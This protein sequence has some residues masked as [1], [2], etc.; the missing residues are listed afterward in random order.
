MHKRRIYRGLRTGGLCCHVPARLEALGLDYA[1]SV[2]RLAPLHSGFRQTFPRESALAFGSWLSLL[3]MSPSRYSHRG[4]APHKFA[5]MLGAHPS[6]ERT[7]SGSRSIPTLGV[8]NSNL[9]DASAMPTKVRELLAQ[10]QADGWRLVRQKGSHRQYH[11][12]SKPG[13]VTVAGQ[14]SVEV[15]PGT[16]SS[17]L[18]Q[19]GL[20]K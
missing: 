9:C 14:E 10:L 18:K 6:F 3:T 16:L 15:P 13:T 4:L 11:H 7:A 8:A 17:I 20:K 19:A 12:A 2:R 1:V 5:P